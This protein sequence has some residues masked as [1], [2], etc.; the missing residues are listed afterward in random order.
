[1]LWFLANLTSIP[2]QKKKFLKLQECLQYVGN[3]ACLLRRA[4][5]G[6]SF[7][8]V[9]LSFCLVHLSFCF[10]HLSLCFIHFL[11][12][13]YIC[14][15]VLYIFFLFCTFV[16]LFCIFVFLFCTFVSSDLPLFF[17]QVT[18]S[19]LFFFRLVT[20]F[21]AWRQGF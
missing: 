11:F 21:N 16:V 19:D 4:R 20:L 8:F 13:L 15:S 17:C 5:C 12:V 18:C 3:A 1:M 14:R 2:S 9:H 10:V 6:L 7:C